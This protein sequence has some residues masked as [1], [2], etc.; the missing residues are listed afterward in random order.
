M[1]LIVCL[2]CLFACSVTEPG[3]IP[4]LTMDNK[5]PDL[6]QEFPDHKLSYY[7]QYLNEEELENMVRERKLGQNDYV[8]KFFDLK[9]FKYQKLPVNIEGK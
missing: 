1:S 3:I 5:L 7:A 2:K 4:S 9:K 6:R 8:A